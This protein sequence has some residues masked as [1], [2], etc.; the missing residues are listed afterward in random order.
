MFRVNLIE[1]FFF[2]L[3]GITL[4]RAALM[5]WLKPQTLLT[6]TQEKDKG[7]PAGLL[8]SISRGKANVQQRRRG[9]ERHHS[10]E[11]TKSK[12]QPQLMINL[13]FSFRQRVRRTFIWR[14]GNCWKLHHYENDHSGS[15]AASDAGCVI[16]DDDA[17]AAGVDLEEIEAECL[18]WAEGD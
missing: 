12:H 17:V 10:C 5:S 13:R 11:L 4:F 7:F 1:V 8:Q 9:K 14:R 3:H 18:A 6:A 2:N 15:E 16:K